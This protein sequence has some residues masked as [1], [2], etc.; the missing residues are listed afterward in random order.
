VP[1]ARVYIV[2]E[3]DSVRRALADRL[4]Q[5]AQ[6]HL[7]GHSADVQS[8]LRE[9]QANPVDVVLVE[10]KR[11]DGLGLELVRQLAAGPNPPRLFVLTS[12]PTK[13]EEEAARRAGA[14]G[15][16]LKDIAADEL[17]DRLVD[18]AASAA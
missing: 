18:G 4:D 3:H 2:D 14:K 17:I 5:S 1:P 15:Y 9:L 16:L 13:W 12:Y 8:A 10:I 6:I 7:V 11:S